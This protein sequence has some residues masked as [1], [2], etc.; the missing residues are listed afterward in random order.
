VQARNAPT[1]AGSIS[2]QKPA[3]FNSHLFLPIVSYAHSSHATDWDRFPDILGNLLKENLKLNPTITQPF[4]AATAHLDNSDD[5]GP[6]IGDLFALRTTAFD[7]WRREDS[8][9]AACLTR[10]LEEHLWAWWFKEQVKGAFR[11]FSIF[12]FGLIG[13]AYVQAGG[14]PLQIAGQL[15]LLALIF[16]SWKLTSEHRYGWNCRT[17][18][19]KRS[20]ADT[21]NVSL[22]GLSSFY[23]V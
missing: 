13:H 20:H 8:Y 1:P 12:A 2:T 5:L 14:R 19:N 3:S 16:W 17:Q 22:S 15:N 9:C 10:F 18:I 23:C 21:K 4:F 7:G 6:F 11:K